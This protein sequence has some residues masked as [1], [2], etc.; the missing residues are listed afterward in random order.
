MDKLSINSPR[1]CVAIIEFIFG[2]LADNPARVGVALRGEL[3]GS[4][5]AV[6]GSYRIIYSY[7][8]TKI[9]IEHIDHRANVYRPR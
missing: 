1:L 8:D 6:R 4:L 5:R 7:D 3:K 2:A 9:Y